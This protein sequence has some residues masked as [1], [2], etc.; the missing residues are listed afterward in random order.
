M[1]G[2][3]PGTSCIFQ[4]ILIAYVSRAPISKQ[5]NMFR[6][7][8]SI[9]MALLCSL[10]QAQVPDVQLFNNSAYDYVEA[11]TSDAQGDVFVI[12]RYRDTTDFDFGPGVSALAPTTFPEEFFLAKY[13]SNC[14]LLWAKGFEAYGALF[15][16]LSDNSG[17]IYVAGVVFSDSADL[18]PGPGTSIWHNDGYANYFILRLDANGNYLWGGMGNTVSDHWTYVMD[19]R[20]DINGDV[21][22]QGL[23]EDLSL[24]YVNADVNPFAGTDSIADP[25]RGF[26]AR[27]S[28]SGQYLG[29]TSFRG[30]LY[31]V[32]S[33]AVDSLGFLFGVNFSGP[34]FINSTNLMHPN[35]AGS[36]ILRMDRNN[37]VLWYKD[38][39]TQSGQNYT[40]I[41]GLERDGEKNILV[42]GRFGGTID[43]DPGPGVFNVTS[44]SGN[45]IFLQKLDSSGNFL[46]ARH[47]VTVNAGSIVDWETMTLDTAGN[48]YISGE[49]GGDV[50]FDPLNGGDIRSTNVP[51]TQGRDAFLQRYN[52]NGSL[53]GTHVLEGPGWQNIYGLWWDPVNE[54]IAGGGF[55][56]TTDFDLSQTAYNIAPSGVADGFL[57]KD[58]LRGSCVVFRDTL[59]AHVPTCNG[60]FTT[61]QGQVLTAS[62]TYNEVVT[63]SNGCDSILT[64]FLTIENSQSE[65]LV[66]STCGSYLGPSGQ[67]WDSTGI[68]T[69]TLQTAAG[70]DSIIQIDLTVISLA[71]Q[72]SQSGDTLTASSNA[73]SYQWVNCDSGFASVSAAVLPQFVPTIS[74]NYA[75]IASDG[76]CQDTSMCMNVTLV[77]MAP[78]TIS[79]QIEVFPNPTQGKFRFRWPTDWEVKTLRIYDALGR[80]IQ[81]AEVGEEHE[82]E[83]D[84][85]GPGGWYFLELEGSPVGKTLV[86]VLKL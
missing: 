80:M 82:M 55:T 66:D 72:T 86:K 67:V 71:L 48:V 40:R 37:Q 79:D 70:C 43:L 31:P 75:V 19:M 9:F 52:S 65:F 77:G 53:Q 41:D 81:S 29:K 13:D 2:G 74:G 78:S 10:V 63:D 27:I 24:G 3:S 56:D 18:D 69:D 47:A 1:T 62:G 61:P 45:G 60:S 4:L 57:F 76:L 23:T 12:G 44:P 7:L 26:L 8:C 22:I 15:H 21:L 51:I 54:L 35:N 32:T 49:F 34:F 36:L 38:I 68:Y 83:L 50:D 42:Y 6:I 25:Y 39:G 58:F 85:S 30:G 46:W 64:I 5:I 20:L 11:V 73:G 84:L 59:V 16:L 28:S 33:L 17:G 14:Q